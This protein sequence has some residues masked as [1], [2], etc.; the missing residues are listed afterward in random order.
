MQSRINS[1]HPLL[2]VDEQV[3][4]LEF[5]NQGTG[6]GKFYIACFPRVQEVLA[7]HF[8]E[9][10]L[11]AAFQILESESEEF[12]F[13]KSL[14]W[15]GEELTIFGETF[16]GWL[17]GSLEEEPTPSESEISTVFDSL[18]VVYDSLA[19]EAGATE[20]EVEESF[21]GPAESHDVLDESIFAQPTA[22][23]EDETLA[24]GD[25]PKLATAQ[26]E[27]EREAREKGEEAP[28]VFDLTVP[29][30][31]LP[32]T[33][34]VMPSAAPES[35]EPAVLESKPERAEEPKV[36]LDKEKKEE[37]T[38]SPE[39]PDRRTR[40]HS[41]RP[42]F[43][44]KKA[45]EEGEIISFSQAPSSPFEKKNQLIV[46][47]RYLG[48]GKNS[49]GIL[50]L[51]G[52]LQISYFNQEELIGR[53]ESS[54]PLLFLL[55]SRLSGNQCT[56]TYWLPPIAFPHPA[57]QLTIRTPLDTKVMSLN[58]LFP[59]SR[60]DY[61]RDRHVL[62]FLAAPALLGF[63]YF[64]FVYGVTVH[65]ID[66]EAQSLF[67]DL[68]EAALEGVGTV[69]FRGGGLGLYRL[70]VVPAS[71]SLQMI[72]ATILWLAPL[73][74]AKFFHFLSR[75]R[76]RRFGG[77]LA[78]SLLLPT[79]LLLLTWNFQDRILPL[80][81]HK[82]FAPLDLRGFLNWGIPTN[83]SVAIYLFLSEFG[84]WDRVIKQ[85]EIRIALPMILTLLYIFV[86]FVV[87]YGRSWFG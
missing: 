66:Q 67:P 27:V 63:L 34:Q 58:S 30:S 60:T 46:K 59:K 86:M 39:S 36:D 84:V 45:D 55:P 2:G 35:D 41:R 43:E 76:R 64:G 71:E 10:D 6:A 5:E 9:F 77:F 73:A 4:L 1:E 87:I 11:D 25:L 22:P 50:G 33:H 38:Q 75:H 79:L 15:K 32:L 44:E 61:L 70:K 52:Q 85:R 13:F 17:E 31:P 8:S 16:L 40:L 14:L 19:S 48:Y 81:D 26:A 28:V 47:N 80:Y 68:Y 56:V 21:E 72:W 65:G 83:V 18:A 54:N 62:L 20:E 23:A 82:D 74:S 78:C 37:P 53:L 69:D 24:L 3:A 12:R 49:E 7:P 29:S 42:N 57:G 51:C